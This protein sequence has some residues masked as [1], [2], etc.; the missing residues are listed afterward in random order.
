MPTPITAASATPTTDSLAS[1]R[2]TFVLDTSVLLAAGPHAL[3]A[4]DEHEVVLPLVVITELESKRDDPEIGWIARAVLA[5]LEELRVT[6]VELGGSLKEGVAV[7]V[8]GG[9]VRIELN[10]VSQSRLPDALRCSGNHDVRILAV[11]YELAHEQDSDT[12][13]ALRQVVVVSRDLPM[14]LLAGGVL[15]LAAQDY[16]NDQAPRD[17][18]S[19]VETLEIGTLEMNQRYKEGRIDLPDG[20]EDLPVNTG[21]ILTA[22]ASGSALGTVSDV[23]TFTLLRQ[24]LTTFELRP[25]SVEQRIAMA[26][27]LN[28]DIGIVS[29]GGRAG[30]GKSS[31]ALA[32]GLEMVLERME[33]KKV[34]VFRPLYAVGGQ[35]LGYLPGTEEE[36]MSPWTAA[37]YDALESFCSKE[38]LGEVAS[39]GLVEILPLTHIRGRTLTDTFVIVDEAQSL[40]R[41]VLL[42]ILSRLGHG[43]RVVLCHDLAQR[44]NLRV[45]RHDGIATVIDKLKGQSLFAHVT[46]TRSERS[47]VADL[48]TRLLDGQ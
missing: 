46:L 40:E 34:V 11:A 10:H 37:A 16:H 23:G 6:A 9:T 28:P 26:R 31:L 41:M 7:G 18:Y 29:L 13:G 42:S 44:D 19:G 43:S 8:S 38:V 27:L 15:G 30:T 47:P 12:G 25:R 3:W 48:V 22:G 45:G 4:F 14:R 35:D 5:A 24:D 33:Q 17:G 2:K 39:R 32:A 1:C 20:A 36:K 21:I